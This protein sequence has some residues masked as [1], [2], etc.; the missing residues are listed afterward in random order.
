MIET[1]VQRDK[2]V[3]FLLML[4]NFLCQSVLCIFSFFQLIHFISVF[5]VSVSRDSSDN[6]YN[7]IICIFFTSCN[8]CNNYYNT[9]SV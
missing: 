2:L 6:T 1:Q 9:H 3:F 7:F 8:F 5:D 4:G